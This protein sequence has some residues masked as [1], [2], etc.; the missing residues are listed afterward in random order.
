MANSQF[1][2]DESL[3][4][5]RNMIDKTREGVYDN[6]KYFLVWGWG[7]FLACVSQFVLKV[8][9][10]RPDHYKVWFITFLCALISVVISLS[11]HKKE[12]VKTYVGESM[13]YLWS[14]LGIT[15]FVIS[16]VFVKIGWQFCYPFFMVLYGLGTFVS[17]K[18]LKYKPLVAGGSISFLLAAV[19]VWVSYDYQ[20]LCAAGALFASYI[21]PAHLLRNR[22]RKIK[23]QAAGTLYREPVL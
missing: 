15:F 1:S 5:I 22:Y 17:G 19:S 20:I 11:D 4:L 23:R 18:I 6:S 7:A 2:P 3:R 10:N 12:R 13:G 21:V 9:Y 16:L 14:G 8:V